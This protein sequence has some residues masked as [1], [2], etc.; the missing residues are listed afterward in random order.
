MRKIENI[1][2][3]RQEYARLSALKTEQE[4]LLKRDMKEIMES[5]KPVNLLISLS[6]DLFAKRNDKALLVKGLTMGLQLLTNRFLS[7]NKVG[8][9]KSILAYIGQNVA[10]NLIATK[11]EG[12]FSKIKG[13]FN[14]NKKKEDLISEDEDVPH[15]YN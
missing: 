5:L 11:S 2:Q 12:I 7:G 10:S 15:R 4:E 13:L 1:T 9:V 8:I 14:F 3:L 6:K